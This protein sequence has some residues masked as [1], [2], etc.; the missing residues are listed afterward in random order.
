[1]WHINGPQDESSKTYNLAG[2]YS[3]FNFISRITENSPIALTKSAISIA[4][5]SRSLLFVKKNCAAVRSYSRRRLSDR[6][7]SDKDGA[8]DDSCVRYRESAVVVDSAILSGL[9][10]SLSSQPDIPLAFERLVSLS[11]VT[12]SFLPSDA[13]NPRFRSGCT[14]SEKLAGSDDR[15][16]A[17]RVLSRIDTSVGFK[18]IEFPVPAGRAEEETLYPELASSGDSLSTTNT[19]RVTK[20]VRA[21]KVYTYI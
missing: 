7:P 5:I 2:P 16:G 8:L 9:Y 11:P 6:R 21:K 19:I 10:G 3:P 18:E 14:A 13:T 15:T 4:N 17:Y 1:M 20:F 12:A